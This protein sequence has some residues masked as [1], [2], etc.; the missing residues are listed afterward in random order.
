MYCGQE[1][2]KGCQEVSQEEGQ[3]EEEVVCL[4]AFRHPTWLA[5]APFF[6]TRRE[7]AAGTGLPVFAALAFL[8]RRGTH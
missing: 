2:E 4:K 6:T 3:E 7:R 5:H 8:R 1:E